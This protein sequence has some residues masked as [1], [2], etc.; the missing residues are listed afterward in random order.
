MKAVLD[1]VVNQLADET[2]GLNPTLATVS[3]DHGVNA[4]QIDFSPTSTNFFRAQMVPDQAEVAST[5]RGNWVAA[6]IAGGTNLMQQ[7]SLTF[8]GSV[9]VGLDVHLYYFENQLFNAEDNANA[10]VYAVNQ[11]MNRITNQHWTDE[12][13]YTGGFN[14]TTFQLVPST[15]KSLRQ[16][17]RFQFNFEYHKE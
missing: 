1:A 4:F 3:E 11:V 10:L 15:R 9:R 12:V 2:Y 13:V 16:S 6:F 5:L 17:I 7:R 14:W 8:S